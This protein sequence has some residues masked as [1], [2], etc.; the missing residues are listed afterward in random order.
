M[1]LTGDDQVGIRHK[2]VEVYELEQQVG[3]R[4]GGSTKILHEGIP[5]SAGGS[6]TGHE[7]AVISHV[8]C[9]E[10][11]KVT[12][13]AVQLIHHGGRSALLGSKHTGGP[14]GTIE[15]VTHITGQH[16]R[17]SACGTGQ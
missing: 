2:T 3:T 9:R 7:R 11:C 17:A 12:C 14:V 1:P 15:R 10:K 8:P 6:C 5:Q 4:G 13:T 16:K